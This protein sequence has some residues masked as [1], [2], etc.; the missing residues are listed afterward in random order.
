M[1]ILTRPSL[2]ST[3]ALVRDR[4]T[5]RPHPNCRCPAVPRQKQ[6]LINLDPVPKFLK[7]LVDDWSPE[8]MIVSYKLET[9][10]RILV[11]KAMYALRRYQH[12]LVIG[13]LLTTR[14]HEVVFVSPR[15]EEPVWI[16]LP[17]YRRASMDGVDG[18]AAEP[19]STTSC[20]PAASEMEIESLI[21][22][23]VVKL[24]DEHIS[25]ESVHGD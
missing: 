12:D 6:L 16:R 19:E 22:P 2:P 9:D 17:G 7:N 4:V 21:I 15:R 14:K 23:A 3:T 25:K 11:D 8:C 1:T 10:P 18:K 13:N 20:E 24:H 5:D